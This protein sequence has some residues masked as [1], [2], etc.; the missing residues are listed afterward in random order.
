MKLSEALKIFVAGRF[1]VVSDRTLKMHKRTIHK[2]I[3]HAGDLELSDVTIHQLRA[4]RS[5]LIRSN[6]SPATVHRTVREVRAFFNWFEN[7]DI[8]E[9]SPAKRLEK[10]RQDEKEPKTAT[11]EDFARAIAWLD[12]HQRWG[13]EAMATISRARCILFFLADTGCRVGGL[14]STSLDT[15]DLDNLE[16]VVLEKGTGGRKRRVVYF[17]EHT[18]EA[19]SEW[20]HFRPKTTSDQLIVSLFGPT[21]GQPPK[22]HVVNHL[23]KKI[24]RDAGIKGAFNPHS[25]RHAAARRWLRSGMDMGSVSQLLGHSSI[26]VTFL[27]YTRWGRSV[28]KQTHKEFADMPQYSSV[29]FCE[30]C[31][32]PI[33]LNEHQRY[34]SK[35]CRMAGWNKREAGRVFK[36][37]KS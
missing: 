14:L 28:L 33:P 5:S 12:S 23:L 24:K 13:T 1:G 16:A 27:H 3:D 17:T 20:L 11:M 26:D 29:A 25:F 4:F 10:P 6:L 30:N 37:V 18:R 9:K 15:L 35:A 19:I 8:I 22:S 21:R 31:G 2:L 36:E 34:C 32:K 7:E